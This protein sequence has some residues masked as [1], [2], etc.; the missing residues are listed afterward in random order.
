ME[1]CSFFV[2]F[3]YLCHVMTKVTKESH[4]FVIN[5]VHLLVFRACSSLP[6]SIVLLLSRALHSLSALPL[7]KSI[8]FNF[9]SIYVPLFLLV[10]SAFSLSALSLPL[11]EYHSPTLSDSLLSQVQPA[12]LFAM[13]IF[14]FGLGFICLYAFNCLSISLFVSNCLSVCHSRCLFSPALSIFPSTDYLY[15][16]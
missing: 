10:C 13:L 6:L 12:S 8:V 15:R 5:G 4:D 7:I 14:I 2:V 11:S 3:S 16:S 1:E 9:L